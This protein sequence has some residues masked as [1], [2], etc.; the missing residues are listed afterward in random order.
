M[1]PVNDID[2]IIVDNPPNEI[3]NVQSIVISLIDKFN[4]EIIKQPL[5]I[6]NSPENIAVNITPNSPIFEINFKYIEFETIISIRQKQK[7]TTPPI[8]SIEDTD[9]LTAIEKLFFCWL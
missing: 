7:H 9:S 5:V 2:C 8:R 4:S 1:L 3:I 6:S